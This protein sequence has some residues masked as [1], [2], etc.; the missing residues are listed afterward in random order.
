MHTLGEYLYNIRALN[1]I[2]VYT[3]GII[4]YDLILL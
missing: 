2:V 4:Y 1:I 3:S